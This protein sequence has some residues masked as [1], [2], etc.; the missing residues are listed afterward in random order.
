MVLDWN[1]L[2]MHSA[3]YIFGPIRSRLAQELDINNTE[4]S[5]LRLEFDMDAFKLVAGCLA[6]WCNPTLPYMYMPIARL[7]FFLISNHHL[8]I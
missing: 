5:L 4:F 7:D 3:S 1:D 6:V 8:D 2:Q